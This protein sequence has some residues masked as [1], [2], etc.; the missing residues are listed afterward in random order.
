M[1][2]IEEFEGLCKKIKDHVG[3]D[4]FIE[5]YQI[6]TSSQDN[7][8]QFCSDG[9]TIYWAETEMDILEDTGDVYS[10]EA[11]GVFKGDEI[12][13]ALVESDFSRDLYWLVLDSKKEIK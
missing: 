2:L 11:S 1:K 12:T 4:G 8:W 9:E 5:N 7:F 10:S 6:D 3:Y 13:L